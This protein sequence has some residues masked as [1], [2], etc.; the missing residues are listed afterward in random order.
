MRFK[1]IVITPKMPKKY[2]FAIHFTILVLLLFGTLMIVSTTV[3]NASSVLSIV[4]AF[5]KQAVFLVV[6][7]TLM[8]LLANNFTM[9]RAQ[10]L[11]MPMF[12]FLMIAM[13][14]T[15]FFT[16]V[17]G[18]KAWIRIPLGFTQITLQPSEFVKTFMVVVLAVY[19]EIYARRNYKWTIVMRIPIIFL[20]SFVIMIFIQ[21]D[22]GTLMVLLSMLGI[23][24]LIPSHK[25]LRQPQKILLMLI[26]IAALL[27]LFLM[28]EQGMEVVRWFGEKV[29]YFAHITTRFENAMNPFLDPYLGGYQS[30]NGLYGIARGGLKGVGFGESIQKYG[31]LTQ[32]DN[33]YILSIV[34]EELGVFGLAVI[35]VGYAIVIKRL[36]Y[37]AFRT[38]SEGYKVILIGTAMYIFAHFVL[39]VGGVGGLIPLTGV[40]LLF[41]S[42]GGSSTMSIMSAIGISQAIIA[43]IRRQG[44]IQKKVKY[45]KEPLH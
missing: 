33:D 27:S 34:I 9:Q 30:I 26:C 3:G 40:P 13:I 8:V 5:V 6:S 35:V 29:P 22:V 25:N 41:I 42:S 21:K 14:A 12:I 1:N 11:L 36:F 31:Y 7:Y 23:C 39:N 18:S 16:G 4:I 24:F 19:V 15:Q 2:D 45:K 28:S 37:Y 32:S 20:I 43:R 17:Y 38:K 10:K 44:T